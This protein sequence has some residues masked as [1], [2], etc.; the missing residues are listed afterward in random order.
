[1]NNSNNQEGNYII[2]EGNSGVG[3]DTQAYLLQKWLTDNEINAIIVNEPTR[4]YALCMKYLKRIHIDLDEKNKLLKIVL[5]FIDRFFLI[6]FKVKPLIRKGITII[7][8]RSFISMM[9]YQFDTFTSR[10][11]VYKFHFFLPKPILIIIYDVDPLISLKRVEKRGTSNKYH[12]KLESLRKHRPLYIEISK[13][14]CNKFAV[15]VIDASEPLE[16]VHRK[17]INI[18]QPRLK[19]DD[20]LNF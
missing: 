13:D 16:A 7:S 14:F 5:I 20:V 19:I 3:K 10:A 11:R 9:V 12:D 1:M 4:F 18:L 8:V 6:N 2:L 17:T 15:E